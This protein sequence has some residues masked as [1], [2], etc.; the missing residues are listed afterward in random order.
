MSP[1]ETIRLALV[2]CGRQMTTNLVPFIQR[3]HRGKIVA[4]VDHD[5]AAARALGTRL[6]ARSASGID[7]LLSLGVDGAVVAVPP[8]PSVDLVEQL[9]AA[10][11]PVYVE[12]PAGHST[13]ALHQL[14][15]KASKHGTYVQVGF[16]FRF[17]EAVDS[18]RRHQLQ[19]TTDDRSC[20]TIDFFSRHPST[21]QWG[22]ETTL[23]SWIRHN[24][25]HAIDLARYL[26]RSEV[27]DVTCHAMHVDQA[28][29]LCQ[30]MFQHESGSVSLLR[31]GNDVS[32][33][34]FRI[35]IHDLEANVFH[36]PDLGRVRRD[37][38]HGKTSGS[39]LYNARNLDHGWGRSGYGPALSHFL[40]R[41]QA[42]LPPDTRASTLR[43][44]WA[45]SS[46][47][48]QMLH[49][50]DSLAPNLPRRSS[51]SPKSWAM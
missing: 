23:E 1:H 31:L 14:S 50:L 46:V 9:V 28:R 30:A 17:A 16:N 18:L 20:V 29:F 22:C 8:E 3:A 43:D 12:K 6:G 37:V 40:D 7:E 41:C 47:C 42:M 32:E 44:A 39:T 21:P 15:M 35:E 36:M 26:N 45:D 38:D 19:S 27:V 11:T 10:G 4:C 51:W 33:F 48:D 25:V 49:R 5:L 34:I 24:G 2:G 13:D